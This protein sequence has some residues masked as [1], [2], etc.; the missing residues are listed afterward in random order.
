MKHMSNDP[1]ENS[2]KK[3]KVNAKSKTIS[4]PT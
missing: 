1:S 2:L 3:S 4:V